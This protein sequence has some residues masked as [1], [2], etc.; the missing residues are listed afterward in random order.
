MDYNQIFSIGTLC[1]L[2]KSIFGSTFSFLWSIITFI[3]FWYS[4]LILMMVVVWIIV[5]ILTR[6]THAYNS[7]NGFTSLFNSFLGASMYFWLQALLYV[8]LEKFFTEMVYCFKWPY[9]LHILVFLFTGFL[10]HIIGI[11]PYWKVF[12]EKLRVR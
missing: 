7:E 4:L 5:E 6:N 12:G 2:G 10:L 9:L 11:W 3:G 1:S 8:I